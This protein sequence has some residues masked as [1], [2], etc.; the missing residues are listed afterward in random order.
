MF[1]SNKHILE[2]NRP[3]RFLVSFQHHSLFYR[4][5]GFGFVR[6]RPYL[7]NTHWHFLGI[8]VL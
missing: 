7:T 5:I 2:E 8:Q 1:Q 3:A 6:R 4:F